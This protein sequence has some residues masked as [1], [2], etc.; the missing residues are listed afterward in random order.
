LDDLRAADGFVQVVDL[1]GAT[2]A[3]GTPAAAG[4]VDPAEEVR[5]LEE[6][7][8][9]WVADILGRDFDRHV[10]SV[11]LEGRKV[12]EFLVE[13]FTGL[14]IGPTRVAAALRA[15]PLDREHPSRWTREE[16]LRLARALLEAA[17]PRMVA[18][19]KCDR[20]TR[21]DLARLSDSIAPIPASGT[22]AEAELTLRRANRSGL[23][24]YRP[25]DATFRVADPASLRPAQQKALDGISALLTTWGSTGVQAA[26]ERMVFERLGQMVVFPV[27]DET[28]WTDTK[29]R[30]LPDA[31]LVPQGTAA[32]AFAYR[33]HTDL[34]ENFVKAVD[35]RTHRALAADHPLEPGAVVRIAARK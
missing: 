30:L 26:L 15:V 34:G 13:R 3:E 8:V 7:L 33:V 31:I 32:R 9:A 25:G 19:N 14:S 23:V 12:E 22:S 17:K 18:A 21:P 24:V 35:G 27:E 6:E 10:R 11:E 29:G 1:T 28:R 2:T 16:R 5:W 20:A 4:S